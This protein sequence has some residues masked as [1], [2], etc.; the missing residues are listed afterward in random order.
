MSY[1]RTLV[2]LAIFIALAAFYYLYEIK[3]G[4]ARRLVEKHE[5]LLFEF[6]AGEVSRLTL[7]RNG[8]AIVLE[9]GGD[10]WKIVEP[11][12]APTEKGAVGPMVEALA[13]LKYDRDLGAQEDLAQFDLS[14]P[15]NKVE[16]ADGDKIFG[17]ISLGS[18]TPEGSKIYVKLSGG[19][20]VFV[21]SD[22]IEG[23]LDRSLFDLRD[24]T[25]VDFMP[26]E[27]AALAVVLGG[28][29][30]AFERP[31]EQGWHMTFPEQHRADAG[32]IGRVLNSIR[33]ARISRFVEEKAADLGEYGLASPSTRIELRLA[34]RVAVLY[35]GDRTGSDDPVGV[36]ARRDDD[37]RVFEVP[38]DI[39]DTLSTDVGDWRDKRLL[40]F[41]TEDVERFRIASK[42]GSIA[43]ARSEDD[44]DE[45]LVTEP[46]PAR[47]DA[48][49][50]ESLLYYLHTAKAIRFLGVDEAEDAERAVEEPA[51]RLELW[52]T[53][54]DS[55]LTLLLAEGEDES[56]AIAKAGP[57]GE[58][59]IARSGLLDELISGPGRLKNRSVIEFKPVEVDRIEVLRGEKSFSIERQDVSWKIPEG[60]DV[61]AYEIDRFLRDLRRLDYT[62]VAPREH[63]DAFYGFDSP[64]LTIRLWIAGADGAHT[65]VVGKRTPGGESRYAVG[66]D[67]GLVMEVK[68]GSLK[69]WFDRF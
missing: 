67:E 14:E 60:L 61:E 24:K 29:L 49:K 28:D 10:D 53:R 66:V 2:F 38:A 33:N 34:A 27:V 50:V 32:R 1:K 8:E 19:E 36:F 23:A 45:W 51:A 18:K 3:G 62:S 20:S 12:T 54:G 59:S 47:A 69:E 65:L 40:D 58:L 35:F 68:E 4:E 11:V 46:E 16:I 52:T 56:E 64:A 41:K 17:E 63:D 7:R 26:S 39:L 44:P 42:A 22:S 15:N 37:R 21:V 43:I 30:F 31:G 57:D 55:P 6:G 13:R 48:D 5:K 9:R 25:V